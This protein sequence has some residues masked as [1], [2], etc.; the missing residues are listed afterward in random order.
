[1]LYFFM[2]VLT[3]RVSDEWKRARNTINILYNL[4]VKKSRR[5]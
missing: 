5:P 1:M 3:T 2:L 4:V